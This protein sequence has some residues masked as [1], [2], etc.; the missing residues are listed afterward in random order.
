MNPKEEPSQLGEKET[1]PDFVTI[2]RIGVPGK[3]ENRI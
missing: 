2:E 3:E 1:N